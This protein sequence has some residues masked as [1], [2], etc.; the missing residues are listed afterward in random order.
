MKVKALAL[1]LRAPSYYGWW[2]ALVATGALAVGSGVS[3][4]AYGLYFESL[5]RDMGWTRTELSGAVGLT[6]ALTALAGPAAGWWVD[7]LGVRSAF[8]AGTVPTAI[9]YFLLAGMRSL[10][11]FY[12]LLLMAAVTRAWLGNVVVQSLVSRWFRWRR[13]QAMSLAS[14]GLGLGG[15]IFTPLLVFLIEEWGWRQAFVCSGVALLAYFLPVALFIVRDS[16][17]EM[18]LEEPAPPH[19]QASSPVAVSAVSY[20][21]AE[22]VRTPVFWAIALGQGLLYMAQLSFLIHAVPFL[23]SEGM[24]P[25]GAAA[26]VSAI[27]AL[28]TALRIALGGLTDRFPPRTLGASIALLQ[29]AALGLLLWETAPPTL[30]VFVPAWAVGQANGAVIEPLLIGRYFGTAHFGSVL[31]ASGVVSSM[32]FALGPF[33]AS[34]L[35][36]ALGNYDAALAMFMASFGLSALCFLAVGPLGRRLRSEKREGASRGA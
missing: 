10:W 14:S 9:T 1:P 21:L 23:R 25:G 29:A 13:G 32:G 28:Y 7:R 24:S 18:G 35:Y 11:H 30:A 8:L 4:W 31:G 12:A 5:E 3:F 16:P 2:M 36:D 6:W 33:L 26:L 19:G 34:V 17:A 20:R 15:F 27:T 22:A